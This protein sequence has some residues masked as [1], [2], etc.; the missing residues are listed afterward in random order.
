MCTCTFWSHNSLSERVV[1][2]IACKFSSSIDGAEAETHSAGETADLHDVLRR[3]LCRRRRTGHEHGPPPGTP[4]LRR[5]DVDEQ[6]SF[7]T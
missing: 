6:I 7:A 5:L 2:A 1:E 4:V 3:S